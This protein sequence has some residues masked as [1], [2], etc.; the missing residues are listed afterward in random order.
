[1][2]LRGVGEVGRWDAGTLGLG[3]SGTASRSRLVL[4]LVLVLLNSQP[5]IAFVNAV[6]WIQ[7]GLDCVS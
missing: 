4:V 2:C 1:M 6:A 5:A 7:V 3:D